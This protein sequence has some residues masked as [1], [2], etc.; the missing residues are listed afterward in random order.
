MGVLNL[1]LGRWNWNPNVWGSTGAR[2]QITKHLNLADLVE[3]AKFFC[4]CFE[5]E[6]SKVEL[7]PN[8]WGTP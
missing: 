4:G 7:A 1:R 8:A 6:A 2:F 5:L 3:G